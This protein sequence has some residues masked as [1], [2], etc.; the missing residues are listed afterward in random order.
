MAFPLHETTG[1]LGEP[2]TAVATADDRAA[3]GRGVLY[4]RPHALSIHAER[5]DERTFPAR[6]LRMV[7]LGSIAKVDLETDAGVPVRV[8]VAADTLAGIG[9]ERGETVFVRPTGPV[10]MVPAPGELAPA[11]P[12]AEGAA[13]R[14]VG[15]RRDPPAPRPAL[16]GEDLSPA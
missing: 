10:T 14:R 8:E 3:R 12:R 2:V 11:P 1:E 7:R 6:V 16:A 4:I 9:L 13:D 15:A 5:V